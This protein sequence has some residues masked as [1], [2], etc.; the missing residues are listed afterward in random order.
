VDVNTILVDE[1][2]KGF[3]AEDIGFGDVTTEVVF[4]PEDH[5]QAQLWAKEDL[6]LAGMDVCLRVFD[7]LDPACQIIER[8]Q[9]GELISQGEC[10]AVIAG[11]ARTLLVGERVALNLLQRMSGIATV[12]REYVKA[13]EGSKTRIADTRKT[14][15][16]L[17]MLE[18]YAVT[19]GGG[20]NHRLRL[21]SMALIKDNHIAAAG[22]IA[23]AVKRVKERSGPYLQVEVEA[24]TIAQVQEALAAGIDAILLDNMPDER[25]AE[26]VKLIDGRCIVEASGNM[27]LQRVRKVCQLGVDVISV[28]ALTHSV[29]AA[30]ISMRIYNKS[31]E[32]A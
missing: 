11:P 17:R 1:M 25:M 14:T 5:V 26:A 10:F 19:V 32:L 27:N 2:L 21:E 18:K 3:L 4:S 7:L 20:A 6:I 29:Q 22:G 30:D 31:S 9:D 12:T 16:G 8:R 23:A 13:A 24:E 15:P 28:G